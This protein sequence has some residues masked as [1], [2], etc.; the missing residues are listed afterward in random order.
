MTT[1]EEIS[2]CEKSNFNFWTQEARFSLEA[3]RRH[4]KDFGP[5]HAYTRLAKAGFRSKIKQRRNKEYLEA[6]AQFELLR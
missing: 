3:F 4:K 5:D 6:P 2:S 1:Y